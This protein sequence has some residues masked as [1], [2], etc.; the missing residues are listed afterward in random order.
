MRTSE[1]LIYTPPLIVEVLSPSNKPE[2]IRRQ[3]IAAFS[4]G[5]REFWVVDPVRRTIEVSLPG[6]P[7]RIYGEQD[8]V[9]VAVL[10]GA[11]L[12]VRILFE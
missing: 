3:R 8:S 5:A 9:P 11:S 4:G 12:P 7:S 10:A 6:S 1:Y 2:K